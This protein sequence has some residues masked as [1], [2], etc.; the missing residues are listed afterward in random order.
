MNAHTFDNDAVICPLCRRADRMRPHRILNGLLTCPHCRAKFV[1]SRSGH[2]VRDPF[3]L[4][5]L[6]LSRTIRRQSHPLA[7]ICRDVGLSRPPSLVALL[8]GAIALGLAWTAIQDRVGWQG[9]FPELNGDSA[10]MVE[11]E[12]PQSDPETKPY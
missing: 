12:A 2:F 6:D 1:V 5:R 3:T 4:R 10:T 11:P 8:G 7:R 9:L